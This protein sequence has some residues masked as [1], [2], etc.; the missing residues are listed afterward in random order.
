MFKED[1]NGFV[2]FPHLNDVHIEGNDIGKTMVY[3][4]AFEPIKLNMGLSNTILFSPGSFVSDDV[5]VRIEIKSNDS[6]DKLI[7]MQKSNE[8]QEKFYFPNIGSK[9]ELLRLESIDLISCVCVGWSNYT[10]EYRRKN[11]I[12]VATFRD[13]TPEGQRLYYSL[14]K[15]HNNK[16]IRILTFNNI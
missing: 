6:L 11:Q 14:K 10:Y 13:L 3:I 5:S 12:W 8:E 15:L 2:Y 1:N 16:E 4:V 9:D 7:D